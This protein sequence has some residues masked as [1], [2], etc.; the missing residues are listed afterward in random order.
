[1]THEALAI[2][3]YGIL[4]T[5]WCVYLALESFVVGSGMLQPFLT[6]DKD[7]RQALLRPAGLHWDGIE[8]WL[9]TA[10]G[11][12]FAAF[13]AVFAK[14][15]ESLYVAF[16]LLLLLLM[17][18]G[19][20]I[21]LAY[22]D[23][24]PKWQA[25]MGT[26]WNVSSFA[27]P[28]VVGVYFSNI[29]AGLKMGVAGYEGTFLGIF[30]LNSIVMGVLFV[31]ASMVSATGWV[32]LTSGK[33]RDTLEGK[34][35][36]LG[37]K[38]AVVAALAMLYEM[39][40]FNTG[41]GMLPKSLLFG[42]APW[43][44]VLPVLCVLAGLAAIFATWRRS[45]WMALLSGALMAPLVVLTGYLANYPYFL[46]SQIK[47]EFGIDLMEAASSQYTLNLMFIAAVIFV[48]IVLVYQGWKFWYFAKR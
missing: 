29:F 10:I 32:V 13:P 19:V 28:L 5:A 9:I 33:H 7:L 45:P 35:F 41:T 15:L 48:P 2:I 4:L 14:T 46:P 47:P 40:A 25:V 43:L 39:M 11:G 21:E 38:A 34:A 36:S 24:N 37:L 17:I 6:R 1:M 3:W 23:D 18:R 42:Q 44:Y 31:A 26:L 8:V 22:K 30:N 12:T 16:F 27:I 20:T